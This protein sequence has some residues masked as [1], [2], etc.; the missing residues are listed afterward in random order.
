MRMTRATVCLGLAA[1]LCTG[2]ILLP[3]KPDN[4]DLKTPSVL[5]GKAT[6]QS[7]VN[8]LNDNAKLMS[9]ITAKLDM[10]CT[11]K[12]KSV[13]PTGMLA[14]QKPRDFRLRAKVFGADEVDIVSNS[15]ELSFWI[16]RANPPHQ[17]VCTHKDLAAGKVRMPFPFQPDM[18]LV[19]LGMADY[20]P[21]AMYDLKTHDKTLELIADAT[22][23]DGKPIKRTVVFHRKPATGS[24]SQIAGHVVK[25]AA[26]K[27][28][29]R[30][31]VEK[32]HKDRS[33]AVVPSKVKIEWP[34]EEVTITLM[35]SDIKVNAITKENAAAMFNRTAIPG[36]EVYDLAK[37]AVTSTT[38]I[39]SAGYYPR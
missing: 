25:D 20:D 32:V 2:C 29:C 26:G 23:A 22:S 5:G 14:C 4:K 38:G 27:L 21:A 35:L 36:V 15:E 9:S 17:Y 1:S 30:A 12:G 13:G 39:R 31:Y 7:L 3:K 28:I 24:E 8:Y 34:A 11:Q 19:A 10:D 37:S 18:V 6:S 16:K 33:G